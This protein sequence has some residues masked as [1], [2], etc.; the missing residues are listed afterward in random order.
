M[1]LLSNIEKSKI[2][3]EELKKQKN[4]EEKRRNYDIKFLFQEWKNAFNVGYRKDVI[5]QK[6]VKLEKETSLETMKSNL[7]VLVPNLKMEIFS[8]DYHNF[9]RNISGYIKDK[10]IDSYIN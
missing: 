5:F 3:Y 10:D 9:A 6:L 2:N 1:E 4:I 8:D 7:V